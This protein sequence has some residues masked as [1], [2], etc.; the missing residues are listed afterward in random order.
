MNVGDKVTYR[1]LNL[2][3]SYRGIITQISSERYGGD[4]RV[5][6]SCSDNDSV[7]CLKNLKLL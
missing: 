3:L 2:S 4:C 5:K 7:E 1:D 6:W